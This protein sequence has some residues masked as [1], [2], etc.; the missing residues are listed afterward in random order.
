MSTTQSA[1]PVRLEHVS[2][3]RR[4]WGDAIIVSSLLNEL[5]LRVTTAV[6]GISRADSNLVTLIVIGAFGGAIRRAAAAPRTQ[7]RKARS[8]PTA[9][10]DTMI[11]AA[12]AKETLESIA[13]H[14]ARDIT[15]AAALITLALVVHLFRP[16]VRRSVRAVEEAGR[17]VV[18][19]AR[20][21]GEAIGRVGICHPTLHVPPANPRTET[22]NR[23]GPSE[24]LTT[25]RLRDCGLG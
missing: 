15:P 18:A 21:I 19:E 22:F 20:R 13:G 9:V 24:R 6:Y 5:R 7:V 3:R 16:A 14:P 1:A 8:S 11:G 4:L 12:T 17:D 25:P 10:G 23:A 2:R